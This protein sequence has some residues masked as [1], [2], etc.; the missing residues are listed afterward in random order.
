M[1]T[2]ESL[3]IELRTEELPPKALFAMSQSFAKNI[4]EKLLAYDLLD[5]NFDINNET[6]CKIF[7]TPRRLAVIIHNVRCNAE[8]KH[9]ETK[10]MPANIG[11]EN[12]QPTIALIKKLSSLGLKADAPISIKQENQ[13]YYVYVSYTPI[14]KSL[15]QE[16]SSILEYAIQKM[17][18]PKL[19]S[20]QLS[21]GKTVHFARPAHSLICLHG[22]H[23]IPATLLG[24]ESGR[25]TLGHRFLND[26]HNQNIKN[27]IIDHAE[28]YEYVMQKYYVI[29]NYTTRK[30]SI[31]EQ[32]SQHAE[33]LNANVIMPESLL[34]EV[35][36]LVEYPRVYVGEFDEN[37]LK[38]PEECLILSMQTHQKYF[39]L[40]DKQEYLGVKNHHRLKNHFLFVSN[41]DLKNASN[42]IEGNQRVIRARLSDAE[43]FFNEDKKQSL[44]Q[45]CEKL[46]HIVYHNKL[47]NQAQR[48]ERIQSIID[49]ICEKM[50][51][52]VD[53]LQSREAAKRACML[54]KC[55]LTTH[56]VAEFPELQ[57]IMGYYYARNDKE[58]SE[59][60]QAIADHYLPK[61]AGDTL[62][63]KHVSSLL[64]L[65]DKLETLVGMWHI[66]LKPT[67]EKDPYAL[68]RHA[69]GIIRI[70]M[71]Y[72]YDCY[73]LK[74]KALL[75]AVQKIFKASEFNTHIT[76]DCTEEI[77]NFCIDRLA[78]LLEDKYQYDR[79]VIYAGLAPLKK[80]GYLVHDI[81]LRLDL[82][83]HFV[84]HKDNN[85]DI[86]K[87]LVAYKRIDTILKKHGLDNIIHK[88]SVDFLQ[89]TA[90]KNL[91]D[92]Y[93]ECA[94][95]IMQE[96]FILGKLKDKLD[97]SL[98]L[99]LSTNLVVP[100]EQFFEHVMVNIDNDAIKQNRLALLK[101]IHETF[102]L[103]GDLSLLA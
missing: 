58:M 6:H 52:D 9:I 92:A 90:E 53:I 99:G 54:C 38:I 67:G 80:D 63:Q 27:I 14:G 72:G 16:L 25:N 19:M 3:L 21:N 42:I 69:L 97:T 29:A 33:R 20:Y 87:F 70:C 36:A 98:I 75:Q 101:K 15:I 48:I 74:F 66:G 56:M 60:A 22:E 96:L 45:R 83:Q 47:G 26:T 100:I 65:A 23:I 78:N 13:Q 32:L 57:G 18:I 50:H 35:T 24:L 102:N 86:Q 10:L 31:R 40:R 41:M 71:E 44:E 5:I 64:A 1:N 79:K 93:Q 91:Y 89:E 46:Q 61:F 34:D 11:L 12:N 62:P 2:K 4:T 39:A 68:R 95:P 49:F 88:V 76:E 30:N 55:D 73:D 94:M 82:I 8:S 28:H 7:A 43:F 81:K 51:Q 77:Y 59:V 17:P 103:F 84:T 85:I 37:F